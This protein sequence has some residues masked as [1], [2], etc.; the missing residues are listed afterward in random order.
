MKRV[1]WCTALL[2]LAVSADA[3]RRGERSGE[4]K[5]NVYTD[6]SY[7]F[8]IKLLDNWKGR[9]GKEKDKVR[10]TAT[11]VNYDIPAEYLQAPDYTQVPRIVIYVDTIS[12]GA[13]PFLD[14]LVSTSFKSK[15]KG[16]MHKE[17]EFLLEKEITTRG[18]R[19][20]EVAGVSGLRWDAE[21]KYIKEVQL[22]A[23]STSGTRVYGSYGASIIA[24]KKDS[25]LY[26]VY[27]TCEWDYFQTIQSELLTMLQSFTWVTGNEAGK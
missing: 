5:E 3:A 4:L 26:L 8:S 14:S 27:M 2:V 7:D 12:I 18:R 6:N 17:F 24:F 20:V 10:L 19:A 23:S 11:Q 22:S 1:I 21:A 16:E 25:M 9:T 13:A 15:Q